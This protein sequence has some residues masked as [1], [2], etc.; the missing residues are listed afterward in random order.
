MTTTTLTRPETLARARSGALIVGLIGMVAGVIG[1]LTDSTAFFHAYLVG[2]G[3]VA[4]LSL[5]CLF[6]LMIQ[7]VTR[8]LWGNALRPLLELGAQMIVVTALLFIPI[9]LGLATIYPWAQPEIVSADPLLQHKSAFLNPTF[10]TI[11]AVVYFAVWLILAWLLTRRS[12]SRRREISIVGLILHFP[13]MTLASIDW[14]MSLEP[15]W[16][17]TIYGVIWL[18]S[19]ALAAFAFVIVVLALTQRVEAETKTQTR[20]DFGNILL[21]ILVVWI[22]MNFIQYLVIWAGDLVEEIG[23]YLARSAGG[24]WWV[25]LALLLF[26]GA[27]PFV[28][29]LS[30]WIKRD[31]RRLAG[32]AL[33][34]LAAQLVFTYWLILPAFDASGAGF[35]WQDAIVPVGIVGIWVAAY[36]VRLAPVLERSVPDES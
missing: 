10:F 25:A 35:G 2:F 3:F 21:V 20:L 14:F 34:L 22:Y 33:L 8:S 31:T 18:S 17:S 26:N 1:V 24:W 16:Y 4:S 23:W 9:L 13:L 7:H 30:N 27:V 29:L 5:G 36:F 28:L 19:E 12:G 15:D 11:R 32:V 6:M